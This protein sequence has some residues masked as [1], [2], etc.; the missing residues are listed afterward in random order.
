[1][2]P[3]ALVESAVRDLVETHSPVFWEVTDRQVNIDYVD[4]ERRRQIQVL[5]A[6]IEFTKSAAPAK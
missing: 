6:S 5:V 2:L 4:E 1:M 3:Q